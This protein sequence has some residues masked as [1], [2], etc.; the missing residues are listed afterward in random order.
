MKA[1]TYGSNGNTMR[2]HSIMPGIEVLLGPVD[3]VE[4]ERTAAISC[5][6][7]KGELQ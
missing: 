2:M 3:Y 7:P 6:R 1:V 5:C 4:R